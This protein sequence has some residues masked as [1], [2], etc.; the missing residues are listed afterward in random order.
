MEYRV[1]GCEVIIPTVKESRENYKNGCRKLVIEAISKANNVGKSFAD[2][3]NIE[4][5]LILELKE[6]GYKVNKIAYNNRPSPP[7]YNQY[8]ISWRE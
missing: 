7:S 3:K 1:I 2:V 6:L 8:E 5:W 4:E